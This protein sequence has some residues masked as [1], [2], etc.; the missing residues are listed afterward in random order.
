MLEVCSTTS[1]IINLWISDLNWLNINVNQDMILPNLCWICKVCICTLSFHCYFV[2]LVTQTPDMHTL[3]VLFWELFF[4]ANGTSLTPFSLLLSSS[5]PS[6]SIA[7][8]NSS[9]SEVAKERARLRYDGSHPPSSLSVSLSLS[10]LSSACVCSLA[11]AV[12][13]SGWAEGGLVTLLILAS[14]AEGNLHEELSKYRAYIT[15][16]SLFCLICLAA[17]HYR[18]VPFFACCTRHC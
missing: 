16:H 8:S 3:P 6:T 9:P 1:M 4:F 10:L 15:M 7:L 14:G 2:N 11:W 5:S 12:G 18:L 17:L 13:C